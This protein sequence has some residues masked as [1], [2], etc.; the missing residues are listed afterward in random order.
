M[1]AMF[2]EMAFSRARWATSALV[3]TSNEEN[4]SIL[5]EVTRSSS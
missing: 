3:L 2:D 4:I 5:P 1:L